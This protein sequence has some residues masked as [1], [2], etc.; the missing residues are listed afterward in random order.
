MKK[1][2]IVNFFL[3]RKLHLST[4]HLETAFSLYSRLGLFHEADRA[5]CI[6]GIS[7]GNILKDYFYI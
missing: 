6:A 1:N 3:Q 2:F 4:G 5:R 7:K